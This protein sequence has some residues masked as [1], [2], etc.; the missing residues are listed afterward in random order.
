VGCV[1]R[2]TDA[3]A[4]MEAANMALGLS[5]E[6]RLE[7][8][9]AKY[10]E[11]SEAGLIRFLEDAAEL[12]VA[13]EKAVDMRAQGLERQLAELASSV[14]RLSTDLKASSESAQGTEL[15]V[16]AVYQALKE[17]RS[18]QLFAATSAMVLALAALGWQAA[19]QFL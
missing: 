11:R 19:S 6:R 9:S 18:K 16:T 14:Q 10:L 4:K 2:V 3:E 15:K 7:D 13:T 17:A 8:A 1:I 12:G 5:L